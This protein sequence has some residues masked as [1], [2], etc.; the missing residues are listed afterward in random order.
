[1]SLPQSFRFDTHPSLL[2]RLLRL[3]ARSSSHRIANCIASS[4]IMMRGVT[5][6]MPQLMVAAVV[7]LLLGSNNLVDAGQ[8]RHCE[9][10]LHTSAGIVRHINMH[11]MHVYMPA[12]SITRHQ[13]YQHYCHQL[14]VL[15]CVWATV[16]VTHFYHYMGDGTNVERVVQL[17]YSCM[18]IILC[19]ISFIIASR[20]VR[21]T[22]PS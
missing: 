20:C 5:W 18:L 17:K 11:I 9:S 8:Q 6:S 2:V 10:C 1:V 4:I 22:S 12:S 16:R 14:H 7:A 3:G 15:L 19:V 21:G 13:R